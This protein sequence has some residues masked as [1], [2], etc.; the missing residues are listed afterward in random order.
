MSS[1]T[2][3]LTI[4][5]IPEQYRELAEAIGVQQLLALSDMCG[6]ATLYVPKRDALV[7]AARDERIKEEFNGANADALARKYGL[8]PRWVQEICKDHPVVI[9]G[10]I[11]LWDSG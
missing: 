4:D 5:M 6:G 10:Q 7:R 8:T 9:N 11:T 2:D 1:W 3:S